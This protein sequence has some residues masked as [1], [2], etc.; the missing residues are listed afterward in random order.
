MNLP[1]DPAVPRSIR[2]SE[3][4]DMGFK[5]VEAALQAQLPHQTGIDMGILKAVL[6]AVC[7]HASNDSNYCFP[8]TRR[9]ARMTHYSK[10]TCA[11]A[12]A[13]LNGM[14]CFLNYAKGTGHG[15]SSFII[16]LERLKE[17]AIDWVSVRQVDG[18]DEE[19][20]PSTDAEDLGNTSSVPSTDT[21]SVARTPRPSGLPQRPQ[22]DL[23]LSFDRSVI[24]SEKSVIVAPPANL[25]KIESVNPDCSLVAITTATPKAKPE[26]CCKFWDEYQIHTP[27]CIALKA[28]A[29]AKAADSDYDAVVKELGVDEL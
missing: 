26:P 13:Y 5:H 8:S 29:K 10:S 17:W 16:D 4:R 7:Q 1:P 3:N 2:D 24:P 11:K 14:G 12:I 6:V 9:L 25:R 20:V 28:K 22:H 15:S 18:N 27:G 19:G 23:N 21:A